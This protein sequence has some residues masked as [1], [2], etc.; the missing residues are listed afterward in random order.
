M[1]A[2]PVFLLS[3]A[4]LT[5]LLTSMH[6]GT[7]VAASGGHKYRDMTAYEAICYIII[8][9]N[10]MLSTRCPTNL[11]LVNAAC[12]MQEY[13]HELP[14]LVV[15]AARYFGGETLP[16]VAGRPRFLLRAR[17]PGNTNVLG[18]TVIIHHNVLG[19]IA[20]LSVDQPLS[21]ADG[22]VHPAGAVVPIEL[23]MRSLTLRR[24]SMPLPPPPAEDL[25][26]Q[27]S[28]RKISYGNPNVAK[29]K[30]SCLFRGSVPTTLTDFGC[31]NQF[32]LTP[33]PLLTSGDIAHVLQRMPEGTQGGK[34]P[35]YM[36]LF[37]YSNVTE[38]TPPFGL[39]MASIRNGTL[40]FVYKFKVD[41]RNTNIFSVFEFNYIRS[42]MA[43]NTTSRS[44]EFARFHVDVDSSV[45]TA[46]NVPMML[47]VSK[48]GI[49]LSNV[50]PAK[51]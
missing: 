5:A 1:R 43:S 39:F 21:L 31:I 15:P 47:R 45:H 26:I 36:H 6:T 28:V 23:V 11:T 22:K 44:L 42:L 4:V 3:I 51:P 32:V 38:K 17:L 33:L 24:T 16:A 9:H 19:L 40:A 8:A 50:K 14:T 13:G 27:R 49:T 48:T 34:H 41:N 46:T 29:V 12:F 10:A 7:V 35:K 25:V 18:M 2:R 20:A 30:T 37:V